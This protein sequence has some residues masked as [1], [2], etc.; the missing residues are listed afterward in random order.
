MK[1][2]ATLL[3][4]F[5][6][7]CRGVV[8]AEF[9]VSVPLLFGAFVITYEMGRALWAFNVMTSDVRA[10]VVYLTHTQVTA[11]DITAATNLVEKG[12]PNPAAG[13]PN[14]APW[15]WTSSPT[16]NVTTST[17]STGFNTSM[18]VI[19]M[20]TAVPI[21]LPFLSYINQLT[22]S[23]ST[24]LTYTLRVSDQAACLAGVSTPCG[25]F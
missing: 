5:A 21:S 15:N 9:L 25:T 20:S 23:H 10:G 16:V 4:E 1:A 7:D 6:S 11:A 24:T 13:V 8:T 18:T 22:N 17:V 19:T 3:R 14:K 2:I 12:S